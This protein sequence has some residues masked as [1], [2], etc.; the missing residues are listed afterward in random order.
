MPGLATV[1]AVRGLAWGEN[2]TKQNATEL[3]TGT[4][5]R[6]EGAVPVMGRRYLA[7]WPPAR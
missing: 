5:G 7:R 6:T 2:G 3:C 4:A 1:R